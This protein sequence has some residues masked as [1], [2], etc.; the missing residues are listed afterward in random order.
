MALIPCAECKNPISKTAKTCPSCGAKNQKRGI[1]CLGSGAI[2]VFAMI[3]VFALGILSIFSDTAKRE[4][5]NSSLPLLSTNHSPAPPILLAK[6]T[7]VIVRDAG[8]VGPETKSPLEILAAI[9]AKNQN[10]QVVTVTANY[11]F[12][13]GTGFVK[14]LYDSKSHYLLKMERH[15]LP[16]V[17]VAHRWSLSREVGA[18][19]LSE[20]A[21]WGLES[22]IHHVTSQPASAKT[23]VPLHYESSP[24]LTAWP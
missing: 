17:S 23:S 4:A 22:R 8:S 7:S 15:L 6:P 3:A 2:I 21:L 18:A 12:G 19:S 11:E 16:G 20:R 14:Y 9:V 10:T 1:G 5:Q 24:S 13:S